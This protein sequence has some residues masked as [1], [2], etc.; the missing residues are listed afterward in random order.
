MRQLAGAVQPYAHYTSRLAQWQSHF[1]GQDA[2]DPEAMLVRY[3]PRAY[4]PQKATRLTLFHAILT[5]ALARIWIAAHGS[6]DPEFSALVNQL[7]EALGKSRYLDG[8][9][10]D[11]Q[12]QFWAL[13]WSQDGGT[14]LE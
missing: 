7:G 6:K 2:K 4:D 9:Q 11:W 10:T 14:L 13:V 3:A 8:H 1:L 5:F 12:Q